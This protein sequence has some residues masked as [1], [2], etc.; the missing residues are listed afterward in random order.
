METPPLY[1]VQRQ[2]IEAT[3]EPVQQPTDRK[4]APRVW[5]TANVATPIGHLPDT[6]TPTQYRPAKLWSHNPPFVGQH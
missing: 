6:H 3:K 2:T 5:K 1:G 4:N